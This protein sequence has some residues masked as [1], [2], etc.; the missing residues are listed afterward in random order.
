MAVIYIKDLAVSGKHGLHSEEKIKTQRFRISVEL[1]VNSDAAASDSEKDMVD[2]SAV[3]DLIVDIV[4][5]KSF[6]L[7]EKLAQEIADEIL[8]LDSRIQ[9]VIVSIDKLDAFDSGYPGVR[10]EALRS[11]NQT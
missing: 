8:K 10:L 7:V 6:N 1:S 4:Q 3:R 11:E 5:D 2:W 9:K